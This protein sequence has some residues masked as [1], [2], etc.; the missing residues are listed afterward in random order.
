MYFG[1]FYFRGEQGFLN[2]EEICICVVNKPLEL[3]EF[4]L[5]SFGLKYVVLTKSSR[6]VMLCI[7]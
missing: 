1:S 2:C 4:V 6:I 5:V 7:V 3:L